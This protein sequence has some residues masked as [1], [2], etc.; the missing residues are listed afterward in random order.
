MSASDKAD[1]RGKDP[2]RDPEGHFIIIRRPTD[3]EDMTILNIYAPNN[4]VSKQT[5]LGAPGWCSR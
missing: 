3:L 5:K 1:R 2:A 4:R